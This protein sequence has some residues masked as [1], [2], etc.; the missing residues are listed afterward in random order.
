[1]LSVFWA[2]LRL[3]SFVGFA[4]SCLVASATTRPSCSPNSRSASTESWAETPEILNSIRLR[5]S[6]VSLSRAPQFLSSLVI[7]RGSFGEPLCE[8][9][10]NLRRAGGFDQVT[11]FAVAS[12]MKAA[13]E[14][15]KRSMSGSCI[16]APPALFGPFAEQTEMGYVRLVLQE[17]RGARLTFLCGNL[18]RQASF[19]VYGALHNFF[20]AMHQIPSYMLVVPKPYAPA[21]KDQ[22]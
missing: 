16:A 6:P 10:S 7:A 5:T 20:V 15:C 9:K 19:H 2:V 8:R 18:A 3:A 12:Q 14:L 21:P 13:R 1:M 4:G 11:A 22:A 17:A